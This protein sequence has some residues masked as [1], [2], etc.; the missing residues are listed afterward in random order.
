MNYFKNDFIMILSI[1]TLIAVGAYLYVNRG[2]YFSK[3]TDTEVNNQ[4]S[5]P[6]VKDNDVIYSFF[7]L[8]KEGQISDAVMLINPRI[9]KD[10]SQKQSWGVLLNA[11]E[12]I[13]LKTVE[14]SAQEEW[15]EN[16][17]KY[18]VTFDATMKPESANEAIPYFGF[19]NDINTRWIAIEKINGTWYINGIATGP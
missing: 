7:Q 18:M 3:S 2:V 12:N 4:A 6:N 17:H 9:T 1:M 11:F 8:V 19:E 13:E 14:A 5:V 15:R 10:E 16:R